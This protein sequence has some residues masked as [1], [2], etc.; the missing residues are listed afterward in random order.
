[1]K[2]RKSF[3]RLM[4][5]MALA[6]LGL[7]TLTMSSA[8][9]AGGVQV[10]EVNP[11]N[12]FAMTN[13]AEENEIVQYSRSST[14]ALTLLG[15]IPTNGNG[16]GSGLGSQGALILNENNTRLYAVN[17]GSDTISVFAVGTT[18]PALIQVI[19]SG[20]DL[21]VS[22]TIRGNLL[23]A[24]HASVPATIF[25]FTVNANGTLSPLADSMRMLTTPIGTPAQISFNPAGNV[26]IITH[27]RSDV[28]RP[29]VNII[30][31]FTVG[32]NGLP[33][34]MPRA[35]PSSGVEPF[36]FAVRSDGIIVV[37]EGFN[38]IPGAGSSSSYRV[39][40]DGTLTLISGSVSTTQIATCWVVLTNNGQIA[41]VT[42]TVSNTISSYTVAANGTLALLNPVAAMTG[43]MSLP[44]DMDLSADGQFLHVLLTGTGQVQVY[45]IGADGS[46][47]LTGQ[48]GG[49]TPMSGAQ[50]LAAF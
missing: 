15:R 32:A 39:N 36:G 8:T 34:A 27:K 41:F 12:V 45:R 14:G 24:L 23:Y 1:M 29:P 20:G 31:T 33:S 3:S 50:G 44:Q 16:I 13:V 10:F 22:L 28:L 19:N 4:L 47:T 18:K 7:T 26:L 17:A 25:G 2:T 6:A 49:I 21:P 46:L 35:N 9:V 11:P 5:V 42:N 48:A 40:P 30:D 43:A 37:S 38:N